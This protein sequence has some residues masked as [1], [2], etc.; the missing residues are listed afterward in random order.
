MAAV[1]ASA[2]VPA[3][4]GKRA[5]APRAA[6][7]A[8]PT[9]TVELDYKERKELGSRHRKVEK[10]IMEAEGRQK[11]LALTMSDPAHATD[12]EILSAASSEA[13]A[14]ADELT[15]LYEEWT[16]LGEALGTTAG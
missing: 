14:L 16:R 15:T 10:R 9:R 4:A 12:Y 7:T 5:A 2:A 8:A 1:E 13:A 3:P 6:S 11:E